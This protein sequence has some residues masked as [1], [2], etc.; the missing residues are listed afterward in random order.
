MMTAATRGRSLMRAA[1]ED[2]WRPGMAGCGVLLVLV[3]FTQP[4]GR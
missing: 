2:P 1:R 3:L 4:E